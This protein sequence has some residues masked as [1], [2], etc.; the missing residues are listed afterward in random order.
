MKHSG[1]SHMGR[2]WSYPDL[3]KQSWYYFGLPPQSSKPQ[4]IPTDMCPHVSLRFVTSC[5][6]VAFLAPC[7]Y[8][9]QGFVISF[10]FPQSEVLLIIWFTEYLFWSLFM[11]LSL[12]YSFSTVEKYAASSAAPCPLR[13]LPFPKCHFSATVAREPSDSFHSQHHKNIF[14]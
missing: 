4:R 2:S 3:P 12:P 5:M 13:K 10:F 8:E 7:W 6:F 1:F 14:S 11:D 9:F